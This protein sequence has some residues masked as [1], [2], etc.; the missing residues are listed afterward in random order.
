MNSRKRLASMSF[1]VALVIVMVLASMLVVGCGDD[2]TDTAVNTEAAQ[3]TVDETLQTAME[4]GPIV[5]AADTGAS[6]DDWT[7]VGIQVHGHWTIDVLDADGTLASHTEF[8]NALDDRGKPLLQSLLSGISG[9]VTAQKMGTWAIQV[10]SGNATKPFEYN[11]SPVTYANIIDA[12]A[13]NVSPWLNYFYNLTVSCMG[14]PNYE[15]VLQG[16]A[17]AKYDGVIGSV[18]TS[19][20]ACDATADSSTSACTSWSIGSGKVLT[21]TQIQDTGGNPTPVEVKADQIISV[22]VAISF[23]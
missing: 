5:A 4:T 2:D 17:T 7:N 23:E 10:S 6:S 15:L 16:Y 18:L 22:K 13:S 14:D 21:Q 11:G 20:D 12:N 9:N 1:A 8:E 3:V 19:A